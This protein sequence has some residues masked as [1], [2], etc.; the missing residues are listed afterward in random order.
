MK[1]LSLEYE[2]NLPDDE[3]E[4]MNLVNADKYRSLLN[5]IFRQFRLLKKHHGEQGNW[6]EA[7]EMLWKSAKDEGLN[8]WEEIF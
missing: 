7:Y 2:F 8:P 4:Y 6:S 1:K 3:Y 5:E